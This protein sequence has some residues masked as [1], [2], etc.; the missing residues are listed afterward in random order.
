MRMTR[1]TLAKRL[2]FLLSATLA[3][4][5]LSCST[6]SIDTPR[7]ISV[8]RANAAKGGGTTGPSVSSANPAYGD[9][10]TT[11]DVHV[12]G[13]GFATGAQATWLLNGIADPA[14]VRTNKTTFVSSTELVANITIAPDA[15]LAFWDV[16]VAL[17]GKNGVGSECFEVTSAQ[18]L[19]PGTT[20]GSAAVHGM[21]DLVQVAGVSSTNN[22]STAWYYDAA[23]GM[24]S[25]GSGDGEAID[26]LGQFV[27]GANSRSIPTAWVRQPNNSWTA[28]TLLQ[29]AVSIGAIAYGAARLADGT[30]LVVGANTL[31]TKIGANQNATQPVVWRRGTDG[32]WSSPQIYP[33]PP[34]FPQSDARDVNGLGQV[35]G[36][37][38]YDQGIVWEDPTTYTVLDG[39]SGRINQAGTL[40]VGQN[41]NHVAVYW[42]RDPQSHQWHLPA[43]P[44]PS[45]GGAACPDGF[46][47]DVNDSGVIVGWSC[48]GSTKNPTVWLLDLS[49][50]SPV[51]VG[52]PTRLPGLGF[53]V[54][55]DLNTARAVTNSPP[56]VVTG[57]AHINTTQR[58]AVQWNLR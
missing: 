9:E 5:V 18:I 27:A 1:P 53:K 58:V 14:H 12:L 49:G 20:G 11:V 44:L 36:H 28:Q 40:I 19:G 51:L 8:G 35:V 17:G 16:Q 21:N 29:P 47:L 33:T 45:L 13:S 22:S 25:L 23:G 32:T 3:A 15:Q 57:S 4:A 42:W 2:H 55:D 31:P 34:G 52:T 48:A 24:V 7:V 26:P 46:G 54:K 30:A 6:E 37:L 56:F 43:T 38:G 41:V 50:P 39:T 10:G